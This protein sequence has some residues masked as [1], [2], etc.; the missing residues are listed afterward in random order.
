MPVGNLAGTMIFGCIFTF[1][2]TDQMRA[3]ELIGLLSYYPELEI[4]IACLVEEDNEWGFDER[5]EKLESI[6]I[7]TQNQTLCLSSDEEL[8]VSRLWS[9]S[10]NPPLPFSLDQWAQLIIDYC[11]DAEDMVNEVRE[12]K[13]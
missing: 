2:E 12:L 9:E 7:D 8:N 11:P 6:H 10:R 1:N 5:I 4:N 3:K 13:S